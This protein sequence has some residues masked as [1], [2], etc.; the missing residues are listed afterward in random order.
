MKKTSR[1]K[2]IAEKFSKKMD[3]YDFTIWSSK[4]GNIRIRIN[5]NGAPI[6][7]DIDNKWDKELNNLDELIK[8]LEKNNAELVGYESENDY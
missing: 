5:Y 7:L 2:K 1:L 3:D 6:Y 4:E 8:F